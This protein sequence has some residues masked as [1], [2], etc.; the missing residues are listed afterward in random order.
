M[1]EGSRGFAT[2]N[3]T[4]VKNL[5]QATMWTLLIRLACFLCVLALGITD[6][7]HPSSVFPAAEWGK[8]DPQEVGWSVSKLEEAR[9]YFETL[10]AASIVVVDRGPVAEWRIGSSD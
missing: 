7:Q 10:P 4:P 1:I 8:I 5:R 9:K 3:S 2:R 6:A